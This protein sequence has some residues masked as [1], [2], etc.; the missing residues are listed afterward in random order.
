MA[1]A[2]GMKSY[3]ALCALLL[4]P[5][6]AFAKKASH[7]G[8]A[9]SEADVPQFSLA[10]DGSETVE[11]PLRGEAVE[12]NLQRQGNAWVVVFGA[13][14]K[15]ASPHV[16]RPLP[17]ESFGGG[18]NDARVVRDKKSIKLVMHVEGDVTPVLEASAGASG[19]QLVRVRVPVSAQA[20]SRKVE[21]PTPVMD[22][23][24]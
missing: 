17:T 12:T 13:P 6:S 4:V 20:K 24:R 9:L 23:E 8:K 18:L 16:F 7:A 19:T 2:T 11:L 21:P 5:G 10:D 14:I 3:F 15:A 1:Y 22:E